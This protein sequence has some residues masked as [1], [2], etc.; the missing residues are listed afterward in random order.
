MRRLGRKIRLLRLQKRWRQIDV[1]TLAG[2]SRGLVS[3]IERGSLSSVSI[4]AFERIAR[5]LEARPIVDLQSAGAEIDHLLDAGH[6]AL[7][8]WLA[9]MLTRCGWTVRAEVSFNHFGDRGRYDLMAFHPYSAMLL[10]VEVK[11]AIGDLQELFGRIDVKVRLAPRIGRQLGWRSRA[12]VPLLLVAAGTTNRRHASD[13]PVLFG[14]FPVRGAVGMRWLREPTPGR[15]PAGLLLFRK[16]PNAT[17]G[18]VSAQQRV[19]KPQPQVTPA[20][21]REYGSA[22]Q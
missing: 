21:G 11:T 22:P 5:A 6:A 17:H 9:S 13:H 16:L 7:A 1:A 2:V 3:S 10:V 15:A 4:G 8:E 14:R 19:R 18:G 12:V 20:A